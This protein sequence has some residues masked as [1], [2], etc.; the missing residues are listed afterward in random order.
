MDKKDFVEQVRMRC[1]EELLP[2]VDTGVEIAGERLGKNGEYYRGDVV[3]AI[4]FIGRLA[5]HVKNTEGDLSRFKKT[6]E[7]SLTSDYLAHLLNRWVQE[8]RKRNFNSEQAPFKT[9]KE[10]LRWMED[11][12][13]ELTASQLELKAHME[14][15][16]LYRTSNGELAYINPMPSARELWD[17]LVESNKMKDKTGLGAMSLMM[18]ILADI[19]PILPPYEW[20]AVRIGQE[21]ETKEGAVKFMKAD[22]TV[23]IRRQIGWDEWKE[24]YNEIRDYF[25]VSK[26]KKL[27][28]THLQLYEIVTKRGSI[29]KGKGTGAIKFWESVN[30]DWHNPNCKTGKGAKLAYQRLESRLSNQYLA[31]EA[32]E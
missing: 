17:V 4:E 19:K 22:L 2:F 31:R 1:S 30:R 15:I 5:P 21:I 20:W 24:L 8:I 29:P 28:E 7:L 11:Q 3:D 25:K 32:K 14:L 23:K 9:H 27:N 18:Y 13:I 16:P 12:S 6:P 26:G 10:A